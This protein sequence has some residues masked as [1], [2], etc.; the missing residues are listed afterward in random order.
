MRDAGAAAIAEAMECGS[1]AKNSSTD[2]DIDEAVWKA[3]VWVWPLSEDERTYQCEFSTTPLGFSLTR[4]ASDRAI[5]S[6]FEPYCEHRRSIAIGDAVFAVGSIIPAGFG[7]LM[8][9][10][11]MS[12]PPVA[13]LFTQPPKEDREL[14]VLSELLSMPDGTPRCVLAVINSC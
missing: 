8:H 11:R 4:S 3:T 10:I 6:G 2:R 13:I 5:V 7:D 14:C 12:V 1:A 9:Q